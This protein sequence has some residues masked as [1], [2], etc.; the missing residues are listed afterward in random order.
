MNDREKLTTIK[1]EIEKRYEYWRKKEHT[2]HSIES[3]IRMSECQHL[4]LLLNKDVG[5][6]PVSE[7]LQ[8]ELHAFVNSEEYVNSIGT[9]GLLLIARHFAD[10]QKKKDDEQILILKDQ[11]ESCHAA[12]KCKDELCN[13]KLQEQMQNAIDTTLY[14]DGDFLTVDYDFTEKGYKAGDKIRLAIIKDE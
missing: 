7:D 6:E 3:E 2:S 4:L 8:E 9:S 14:L 13:I 1:A 5:I 11:V 10:W 12:T